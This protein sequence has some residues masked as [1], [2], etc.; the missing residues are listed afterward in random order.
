MTTSGA[1]RRYGQAHPRAKITDHDIS[2]AEIMAM[3]HG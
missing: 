2:P 1:K 3:G